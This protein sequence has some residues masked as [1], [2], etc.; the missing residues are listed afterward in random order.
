MLRHQRETI[1]FEYRPRRSLALV[2]TI[3]NQGDNVV[4]VSLECQERDLADVE[5]GTTSNAPP[6]WPIRG[7]D[8][9]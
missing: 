5:R 4:A 7:N 9:Y 2:L 3:N 8:Y 6:E 1:H